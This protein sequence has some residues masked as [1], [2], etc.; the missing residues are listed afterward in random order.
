MNNQS[1]FPHKESQI[2]LEKKKKK[3]QKIKQHI[4]VHKETLDFFTNND[5]HKRI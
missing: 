1:I 5:F 4:L 2:K 3:S